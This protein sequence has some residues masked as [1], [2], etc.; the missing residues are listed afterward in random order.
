MLTVFSSHVK[1]RML[2]RGINEATIEE[3]INNPD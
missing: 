1:E 3:I 2:Q